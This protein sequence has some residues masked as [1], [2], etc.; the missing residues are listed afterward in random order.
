MPTPTAAAAH[1]AAQQVVVAL[2]GGDAHAAALQAALPQLHAHRARRCL[3]H[4]L[5]NLWAK[6]AEA[7]RRSSATHP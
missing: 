4:L 3:K 5:A 7:A 2:G 1:L 6:G